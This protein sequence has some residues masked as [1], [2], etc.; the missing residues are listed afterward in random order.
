M[1]IVVYPV[2]HYIVY[3]V[4]FKKK[5]KMGLSCPHFIFFLKGEVSTCVY[6]Y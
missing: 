6:F 1:F 4:Y 3:C 5:S 2:F